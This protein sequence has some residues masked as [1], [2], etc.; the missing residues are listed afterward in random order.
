MIL[1]MSPELVLDLALRY[2]KTKER[3]RRRMGRVMEE[4]R[5]R[6]EAQEIPGRKRRNEILSSRPR[7]T[8]FVERVRIE[9]KT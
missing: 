5:K 2:C 8:W 4:W 3:M 7:E 1:P 6:E 9:T